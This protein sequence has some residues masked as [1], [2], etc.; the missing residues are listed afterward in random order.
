[1]QEDRF[2]ANRS[3]GLRSREVGAQE[4]SAENSLRAGAAAEEQM[5]KIIKEREMRKRKYRQASCARRD[6][7]P[8]GQ[9]SK[10]SAKPDTSRGRHPGQTFLVLPR[11]KDSLLDAKNKKHAGD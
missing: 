5:N 6:Y 8:T 2:K 10:T 1:M 4:Q 9:P 11:F 3:R 7:R